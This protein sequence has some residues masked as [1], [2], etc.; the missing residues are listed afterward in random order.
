MFIVSSWNVQ[1]LGRKLDDKDFVGQ[2]INNNIVCLCE[3]WLKSDDDVPTTILST[4]GFNYFYSNRLPSKNRGSGGLLCLYKS[5]H[6][7]YISELVSSIEDFLIMRIS[8][9]LLNIAYDIIL[10]FV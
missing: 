10:F 8:R 9:K 3:T 7:P 6:E 1:G 2:L 4:L 5:A